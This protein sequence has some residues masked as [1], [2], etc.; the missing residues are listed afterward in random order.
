M[1]STLMVHPI[2]LFD[3][4]VLHLK[5]PEWKTMKTYKTHLRPNT[6]H[7]TQIRKKTRSTS[8]T[9][10]SLK[11]SRLRFYRY[12]YIHV[13]GSPAPPPPQRYPPPPVDCGGGIHVYIHSWQDI[14]VC[15]E[16]AIVPSSPPPSPLS[17]MV[18]ACICTSSSSS[19]SSSSS[20][21]WNW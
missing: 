10:K 21:S 1:I 11:I 7:N 2:V 5:R 17:P 3:P 20:W 6:G 16:L 8:K 4:I 14:C 19:S 9:Q 12:I 13:P 15:K 18:G